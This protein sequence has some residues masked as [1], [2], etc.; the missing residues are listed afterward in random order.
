MTTPWANRL[1]L[2]AEA[3][4][5]H[6]G[7]VARALQM[8]ELAA[9]CGA[10]AVKF[11]TFRSEAL[12]SAKLGMA[13]Y[14]RANTGKDESQLAMLRQLELPYEAHH[15]L[16]ERAD[17]LGIVFFSTAFDPESFAFLKGMEQPL[18]KIPSGEITNYPYLADIGALDRPTVLSTG[19]ATMA[20]VAAAVDVLLEH[21]LNRGRLCIL[22]CNTEYPTPWSDVNLRAMS[23]LGEAIGCAYGYSDHTPGAEISV[24]AAALGARVIE[25]HFTLDKALPGPDHKASLSPEE[26]QAWVVQIRHVESALGDGIKRPTPSEAKNRLVARKVLVAK[27]AIQAGQAFAEENLAVKRAG[28][29]LSPMMW[30]QVIGRR[31]ARDFDV[32][33]AIE[34]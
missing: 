24:A 2:I 30:P 14:Q 19:M 31:A 32:D 5:N 3:G 1:F 10:N 7:D 9:A 23:R 34:L 22:H 8:V 21:G 29:G 17:S 25:K 28:A 33:E 15:L 27:S 16:R 6:N 12:V 26:L 13:D 11:Q 4:V 20:E 18:W